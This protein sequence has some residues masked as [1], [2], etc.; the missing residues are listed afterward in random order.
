M[1][2]KKRYGSPHR[3]DCPARGESG[4]DG[5]RRVRQ[6][7]AAPPA[8]PLDR[9]A[10]SALAGLPP[11]LHRPPRASAALFRRRVSRR[12]S[13]DQSASP[14][15]G[16]GPP[17]CS[18]HPTCRSR[19]YP[20]LGLPWPGG[21][22]G[23]TDMAGLVLVLTPVRLPGTGL[24]VR[25]VPP[26]VRAAPR[27]PPEPHVLPRVPARRSPSEP[28]RRGRRARKASGASDEEVFFELALA[29]L[30]RAAGLF[31]P[32]HARTDKVDGWVSLEVSRAD[33]GGPRR[34][35]PWSAATRAGT[36]RGCPR[37]AQRNAEPADGS[38]RAGDGVDLRIRLVGV[39]RLAH[40][41]AGL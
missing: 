10:A 37:R 28:A 12:S 8:R 30:R 22:A 18:A 7:D 29:D 33:P 4:A 38:P 34:R 15:A 9:G 17:A 11:R 2:E 40:G 1:T 39:G 27:G 19:R 31:A 20:G 6:V 35:K 3:A 26:W 5:V 36:S 32:V 25:P 21:C 23:A 24:N 41:L 13:R 16:S 14:P